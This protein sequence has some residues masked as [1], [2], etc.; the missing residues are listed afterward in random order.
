[1]GVS[2]GQSGPASVVRLYLIETLKDE[3][4]TQG[5]TLTE[6]SSLNLKPQVIQWLIDNENI[7]EYEEDSKFVPPPLPNLIP[8]VIMEGKEVDCDGYDGTGGPH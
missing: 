3:R 7:A 1:M 8:S 2:V 4:L 5:A 6:L